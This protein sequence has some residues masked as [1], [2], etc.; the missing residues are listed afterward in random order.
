[1][2]RA[3][4]KDDISRIVEMSQE[5]WGY[6]IYKDEEFQPNFVEDMVQRCIDDK[7]CIVYEENRVEGFICG[8][9]GPLLAN[10][11]VLTATELAW[12]VS[13]KYRN[14]GAG[15]ALIR[16]FEKQ[17]REIGVKY[18]NMAYMESSMPSAISRIYKSMGY[19]ANETLY[20]KVM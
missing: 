1:M 3:A 16:E 8:V 2:I 4:S 10:E 5:F 11:D 19:Q 12:W 17:A 18:L 14:S 20:T 15:L 7:L 13:E 6:T 9:A